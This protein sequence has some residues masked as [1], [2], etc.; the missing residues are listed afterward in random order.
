MS[1]FCLLS[2]IALVANARDE[3]ILYSCFLT[4]PTKTVCNFGSLIVYGIIPWNMEA[5]NVHDNQLRNNDLSKLHDEY[6]YYFLQK[7]AGYR[8]YF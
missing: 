8:L 7:F 1:T 4:M 5:Q 2:L 3:Y 6:I